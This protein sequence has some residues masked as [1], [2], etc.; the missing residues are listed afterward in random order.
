MQKLKVFISDEQGLASLEYGVIV[1][2]ISTA[3]VPLL[4]Q[5]GQQLNAIFLTITFALAR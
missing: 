4:T 2:L 3:M 5:V 1:A